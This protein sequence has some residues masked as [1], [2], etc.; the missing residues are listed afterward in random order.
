MEVKSKM[1]IKDDNILGRILK[2]KS[3]ITGAET[4]L[5]GGYSKVAKAY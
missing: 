1:S 4:E 3:E 5:K 2:Y